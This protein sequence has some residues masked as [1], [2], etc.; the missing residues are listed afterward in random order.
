MSPLFFVHIPKTAGTSFR[1]GAE[2]YFEKDNILYDYG[3]KSPVTA[4]AV[5]SFLYGDKKDFWG[6][7]QACMQHRTAMVGGHVNVNRFISLFGV[8]RTL[9]F[10]RDPLQRMASEYLHFVRNYGFEG[11]FHDFYSRPIMHNRQSKMLHGVDVEAIG[12]LGLTERYSKSLEMI[13]SLYGVEIPHREDNR[14]KSASELMHEVSEKDVQEFNQFNKQDIVMYERSTELFTLRYK[15]FSEG[16]SWGHARLVECKPSRLAGWAW[17]EGERDDPVDVEI[18]VNN[19]YLDTVLAVD[20]R[21]GLCRH[22]PPRGG[23]VGFHLPVKLSVGDKVQC[24]IGSTGQCFPI[25]PRSVTKP[26]AK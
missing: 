20:F 10:L 24:R 7:K 19:E 15:V 25:K 22:L 26:D 23:Y 9:T 12:F 18:W 21:P 11:S 4:S 3:Q 16:K 5:K 13:N 6:F 1:L 2:D 17:W 14:G 8:D